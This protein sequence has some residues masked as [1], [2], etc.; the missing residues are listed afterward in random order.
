MLYCFGLLF[1]FLSTANIE[2]KAVRLEVIRIKY[3]GPHQLRNCL[4]QTSVDINDKIP[5]K[6][7]FS[8]K[9]RHLLV[10]MN[11]SEAQICVFHLA[12]FSGPVCF[13]FHCTKKEAYYTDYI[14]QQLE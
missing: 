6:S 4:Y 10:G 2:L 3:Q 5:S 13:S 8:G 12:Q 9:H 7:I 11:H 14:E 1:L